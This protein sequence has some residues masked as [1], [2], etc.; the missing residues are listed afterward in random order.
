[1]RRY[2]IRQGDTTT[3]DGRVEACAEGDTID[4]IPVAYERDRVWCGACNTFGYI[5]CVGPRLATT[6]PDGRQ[7]ALSDDLCRCQCSPVP[8]LIASQMRSY[9]DV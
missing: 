4:G 3:S 8:R 1:M 6:G 9:C 2:D 5:E 7:Q